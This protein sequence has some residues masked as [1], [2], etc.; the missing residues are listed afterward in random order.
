MHLTR[1]LKLEG[2]QQKYVRVFFSFFSLVTDT[3]QIH[4]QFFLVTVYS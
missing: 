4:Q 3:N 1:P 2:M